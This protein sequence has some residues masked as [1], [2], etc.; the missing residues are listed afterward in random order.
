MKADLYGLL[1][2]ESGNIP[3]INV[4]VSALLI[5]RG[6]K[7]KVIQKFQNL[8]K[9]PLE[10]VYKFPLPEGA[11]VCGFK[12]I[13]GEKVITAY[14][15]ERDKAFEYYDNALMDG[16]GAYL[17]D[18]ERPNIFTLSIGNLNPGSSAAIEI[19]YITLLETHDKEVRFF[20]PTTISPRYIPNNISDDDGIPVGE[21]IN[22]VYS[23]D[24]PY[25]L[26][27]SID[28][29]NAENIEA[30]ESPSH[31]IVTKIESSF[32]KVKFSAEMAKMD[33]DFVLNILNRKGFESCAYL[34]SY[35]DMDYIQVDC[36]FPEKNFSASV[37][38]NLKQTDKEMIFVLDCSGSMAGSSIDEAKR[39]IE[40]FLK[41]LENGIN[42]NIYRFGS[43]FQKLFNS[44]VPYTKRNLKDAL[45][46]I[47]ETEADLGGTE[48]LM[49][50]QDIFNNNK[51]NNTDIILIT[52]GEV[53]NEY[54]IISLAKENSGKKRIFTVGIGYG[55]NEYFIKQAAKCSGG[56]SEL[57]APGERIE[58]KILRL[59]NK[60]KEASLH[61]LKIIWNGNIEQSPASVSIFQH[62]TVSIFV[63]TQKITSEIRRVRIKGR[64]N[65]NSIEWSIPAKR[66]GSEGDFIPKLWA[67][68][69]IN[70]LEH[71]PIELIVKESGSKQ[72]GRKQDIIKDRIIDIAKEHGIV[73]KE[74]SLVAIEKRIDA[75]KTTGET[76]LRKV[77]VILTKDWGGMGNERISNI[78]SFRVYSCLN[79][80]EVLEYSCQSLRSAP[81]KVSD[82]HIV[83][84]I[85]NLQNPTGG[86]PIDREIAKMLGTTL[87]EIRK[88]SKEIVSEKKIDKFLLLCTAII[89]VYLK[90]RWDDEKYYWGSIVEK[91]EK[92]LRKQIEEGMPMI[93]GCE[94]MTWV[95]KYIEELR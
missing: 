82:D 83:I 51:E 3:L 10:A 77:P 53:G 76:I 7:V 92:W 66:I 12:A 9:S 87:S 39:A 27:I 58:P 84:K 13:I 45:Q 28:I 75:E 34:C 62:D 56:S 36:S 1:T 8:E 50:L 93:Y 68:E 43:N 65:H 33:R 78:N 37:D 74:T 24:N 60:V 55:P 71:M 22:P 5:G 18:Q 32:I 91:S 42:F 30:V 86:F 80:V 2:K 44:A 35:K 95:E 14:V 52:D 61:D 64:F 29:E 25:G 59:F 46:Y 79:S 94:L 63:K 40:I 23:T 38:K 47:S 69:M 89:L 16:D 49:P 11:A 20:L 6:A 85:L 48:I 17:F 31:S 90:K 54:E 67:R 73:S 21:K 4:D 72:E 41:G 26:S 88:I 81:M 19:E 15:E 57:V 70:D